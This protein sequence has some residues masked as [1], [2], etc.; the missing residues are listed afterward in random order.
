MMGMEVRI[1]GSYQGP[2]IELVQYYAK[3][4]RFVIVANEFVATYGM[5]AYSSPA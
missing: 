2:H 5:P 1:H 3:T 4:I